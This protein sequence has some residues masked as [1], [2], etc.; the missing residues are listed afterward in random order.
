MVSWATLLRLCPFPPQ[1]PCVWKAT[2]IRTTSV[3]TFLATVNCIHPLGADAGN[4]KAKSRKSAHLLPRLTSH[5]RTKS[6]L[7]PVS[8]SSQRLAPG[9]YASSLACLS[10]DLCTVNSSSFSLPSSAV[11]HHQW[12]KL[13]SEHPF[14]FVNTSCIGSVLILPSDSVPH[15]NASLGAWSLYCGSTIPFFPLPFTHN[16]SVSRDVARIAE[17]STTWLRHS[18]LDRNQNDTRVQPLCALANFRG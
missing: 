7:P 13:C 10:L 8:L 14:E 1:L 18:S 16:T 15:Q 12:T 2:Y 5:L 3:A 9:A 17:Q 6:L 11:V 4:G